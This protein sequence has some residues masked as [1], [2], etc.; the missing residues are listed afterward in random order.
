LVHHFYNIEKEENIMKNKII[1]LVTV[2]AMA[3]QTS[4]L[5]AVEKN[6][7]MQMSGDTENVD[8]VMMKQNMQTMVKQ[9]DEIHATK[10]PK[11]R[12]MLM[13]EHMK[14][15]HK[16]MK[17]MR[18]M[19]G[20][21]M[22]GMMSSKQGD[23]SMMGKGMGNNMSSK[24][25]GQRHQMMEQRMDMMQMMMEQMMGRMSMHEGMTPNK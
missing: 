18:G 20:D 15:M 12:K 4:A 25:K 7:S 10:D 13:H 1:I 22:M 5:Y 16:G 21:M 24:E 14:N 19:G 9:M 6:K 11:K 8:M 3:V 17:M 2:A 23:A